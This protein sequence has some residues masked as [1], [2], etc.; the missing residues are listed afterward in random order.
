[1]DLT[2]YH[3]CKDGGFYYLVCDRV[4]AK[5]IQCGLHRFADAGN[6]NIGGLFSEKRED[7]DDIEI[8]P[9]DDFECYPGDSTDT[10]TSNAAG[11]LTSDTPDL[12]D[13][14]PSPADRRSSGP[15]D[16]RIF[17]SCSD[18]LIPQ[19]LPMFDSF[20]NQDDSVITLKKSSSFPNFQ[21]EDRLVTETSP[22]SMAESRV[23][24][25]LSGISSTPQ[26]ARLSNRCRHSSA[27]PGPGEKL[28]KTEL[29]LTPSIVSSGGSCTELGEF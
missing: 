20:F 23:P 21:T 28:S 8:L 12:S 18:T 2:G 4:R 11:K 7:D 25:M 3:L 22:A 14:S 16:S 10:S 17:A 27:P 1:M 29:P 19:A 24:I 13:P 15:A 5:A 6:F 26:I 9:D